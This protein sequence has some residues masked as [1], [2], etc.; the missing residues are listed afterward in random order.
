MIWRSFVKIRIHAD[1]KYFHAFLYRWKTFIGST[2]DHTTI[3][4]LTTIM[5]S[6]SFVYP[7]LNTIFGFTN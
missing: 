6:L 4:L 2:A 7:A 5:I 3:V 1:E